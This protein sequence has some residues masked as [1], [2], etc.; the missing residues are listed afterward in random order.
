MRVKH[1]LLALVWLCAASTGTSGKEVVVT[2]YDATP[3]CS[4]SATRQHQ[5]CVDPS[6][7][8]VGTPTFKITTKNGNSS[9]TKQAPEPN[10]PSCFSI[11]TEVVPLGEACVL[12]ICNCRGNG[13]LGLEVHLQTVPK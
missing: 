4:D 12:G 2:L 10:N 11:T 13:W 5:V 9:V 8:I 3:N 7:R 6:E 1:M